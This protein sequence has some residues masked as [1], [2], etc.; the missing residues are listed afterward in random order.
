MCDCRNRLEE[1][2]EGFIAAF[3]ARNHKGAAATR[4]D[5]DGVAFP[6]IRTEG[7]GIKLGCV[8]TSNL[9]V[10]V[11]GKKKPVIVPVMHSF[12][13]LCGA[14]Y[15]QEGEQPEDELIDLLP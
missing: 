9:K 2:K 4:I 1:D 15:G 8:T 14:K 6:M 5:F 13:P 10:V 3:V 7:D 12:C 11:E